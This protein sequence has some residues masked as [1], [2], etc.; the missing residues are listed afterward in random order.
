[1]FFRL[2]LVALGTL[3]VVVMLG[4]AASASAKTKTKM[5][6]L[7][8][9]GA[10]V[11]TLQRNLTDVG[12]PTTVNGRY[13]VVTRS[14]VIIF[15]REND[16]AADG[17]TGPQ[18]LRTL[19]ARIVADAAAQQAATTAEAADASS[20][21]AGLG[22]GD[23]TTT[24]TLDAGVTDAPALTLNSQGLV[25]IPTTGIPAAMTAMLQA[26]NKIA[27]DPYVY[28]G[29]HNGWKAAKGYDCSGS[30][31]YVLHAAGLMVGAQGDA[32][33]QPFDST[34]FEQF[35]APGQSLS[36]WATMW[37]NSWHVYL[38]ISNLWFDTAA[39][40]TASGNDRWSTKR[41]SSPK[42]FVERHPIGW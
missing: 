23:D 2:R 35:G 39:L 40:N 42:S 20:G 7:G 29:G 38:K 27:H 33:A 6:R 26:A 21:G 22:A 34:Q 24:T 10:T 31:S 14:H 37:T 25:N 9:R 36:G 12:V 17:I 13:T 3:T 30:T 5:L 28:G 11:R 16:I 41:I 1:M 4:A 15:Q 8:S 32:A 19:R 18:T